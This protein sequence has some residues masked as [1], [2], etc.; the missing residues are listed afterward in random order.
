[1]T[2]RLAPFALALAAATALAAGDAE[3]DRDHRILWMRNAHTGEEIRFRPFRSRSLL[4]PVAWARLNR[5]MRSWRT[6]KRRTMHPRL[7]R[8]LAQV[9]RHFGG[10]RIELTSGYRVPDV[11]GSPSSYHGVGRAADFHIVG[12]ANRE[13]FE[14]C[15]T[16]PTTG[17]G[18]Y[19]NGSH[20]HMDVRSRSAIWVDLSG[21][22]DGATFVA[23]PE[24]WLDEH[25]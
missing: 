5:F 16:L 7:L 14:Y 6:E 11:P 20:V 25:P 15:R 19:P 17:C 21:Y 4:E 24:R 9:Q 12:V 1:M 18:Y 2:V 8:L 3:A 10:H 22:G 13:I 23:D